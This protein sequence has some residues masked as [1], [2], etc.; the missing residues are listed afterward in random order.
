MIPNPT[1]WT[2]LIENS[3]YDWYVRSSCGN[4]EYSEWVGPS[5][6]NTLCNAPSDLLVSNVAQTTADLAWT[7]NGSSTAW[8]IVLDITGFDPDLATPIIISVIPYSA[9]GLT[10]NSTSDWYVR[11]SCG[12]GEYSEWV[13][14]S[15]FN[16]LCN[17]PSDLLVSNVAQTTAD[18]AWTENGSKTQSDIITEKDCDLYFDSLS[19]RSINIAQVSK[20]LLNEGLSAFKSS[21]EELLK[22]VKL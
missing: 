4:G 20:Q 6:F 7:E 2:G 22:K 9:T 3:T 19:K 17:A 13:G 16:T 5:S 21:F 14:P 8:E 11:S 1:S 18:L 10:E 12:N 15:S